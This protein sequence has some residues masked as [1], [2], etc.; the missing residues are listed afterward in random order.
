MGMAELLESVLLIAFGFGLGLLGPLL[1]GRY[2]E[3]RGKRRVARILAPEIQAVAASAQHSLEVNL[4]NLKRVRAE[5]D[6][7][8]TSV[9]W[10]EVA[11]ADFPTAV[12][13]GLLGEVGIL[14]MDV[15]VPL[16]EMYRWIE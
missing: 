14:P 16:T 9:S 3:W 8:P 4:P 6:A 11:D 15:L 2:D 12:F 10:I 1:Q 5:F 7:G 13:Q